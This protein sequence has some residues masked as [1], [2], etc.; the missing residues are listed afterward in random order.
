MNAADILAAIQARQEAVKLIPVKVP[1]W[2]GCTL[3]FPED[4]TVKERRA[5]TQGVPP[6]DEGRLYANYVMH[7][8]RNEK[9]EKVFD[10][11]DAATQA[12]F[13]GKAGMGV[14]AR[15]V[16]EVM[17]AKGTFDVDSEKNV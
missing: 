2:G 9:G 4:I 5:A 10:P 8:A 16:S 13:Q 3:Y 7:H 6:D 1:E 17:G 12:T 15:I 11:M 14:V